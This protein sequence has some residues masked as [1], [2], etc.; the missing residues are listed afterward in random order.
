[1]KTQLRS[2]ALGLAIGLSVLTFVPLT[3]CQSTENAVARTSATAKVTVDAAMHSWGDYVKQFHPPVAQ[4]QQVKAAFLK[5]QQAQLALLDAVI[6]YKTADTNGISGAQLTL[7]ASVA[8]ASAAL[9]D[10]TG[11]IASFGVKFN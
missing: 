6:A 10:L 4:E 8:A 5:Y 3:G 1:M 9:A 11:L 7:N 2:I